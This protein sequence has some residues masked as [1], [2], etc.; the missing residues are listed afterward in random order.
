MK[1]IEKIRFE[2]MLKAFTDYADLELDEEINF[3]LREIDVLLNEICE[4]NEDNEAI[5]RD[6]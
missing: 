1:K 5:E 2:Q 3:R 6:F 4:I